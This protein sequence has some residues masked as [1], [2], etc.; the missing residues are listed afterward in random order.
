MTLNRPDHHEF[1]VG[2]QRSEI[3][4]RDGSAVTLLPVFQHGEPC[5]YHRAV[6][7]NGAVRVIDI[8]HLVRQLGDDIAAAPSRDVPG[9]VFFT[10][11]AAFPSAVCLLDRVNTL[12]ALVHL[13]PGVPA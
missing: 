1:T 11:R 4:L 5:P 9:L 6:K 3:M 2:A 12:G 10:L 8:R 13:E 7:L